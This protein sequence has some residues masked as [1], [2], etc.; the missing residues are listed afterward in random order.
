MWKSNLDRDFDCVKFKH[1]L[2]RNLR[3]ETD[4]L[5][6]AEYV[7]FINEGAK[8]SLLHKKYENETSDNLQETE[9]SSFSNNRLKYSEATT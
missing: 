4:G 8:K 3:K 9:S 1:D 2:Q 5:S 6:I 7:Q